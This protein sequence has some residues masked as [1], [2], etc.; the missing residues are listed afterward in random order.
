MQLISLA[1]LVFFGIIVEPRHNSC[2][3]WNFP[4]R[5][6]VCWG[7]EHHMESELLRNDRWRCTSSIASYSNGGGSHLNFSWNFWG[8]EKVEKKYR[9][10]FCILFGQEWI[11][12]QC[13]CRYISPKADA[14]GSASRTSSRS[15][16]SWHVYV[17]GC[18][19]SVGFLG[20]FWALGWELWQARPNFMK[21]WILPWC[22]FFLICS[23]IWL[24]RLRKK[25]CMDFACKNACRPEFY[26]KKYLCLNFL[27]IQ[28]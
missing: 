17:D 4:G 8:L 20:D 3:I 13:L 22:F 16:A 28:K 10:S 7:G 18:C 21:S 11:P 24:G 6:I 25:Q 2:T 27:I 5:Q 1:S 23:Q 14:S 26:W 15:S 12:N 19:E 9:W